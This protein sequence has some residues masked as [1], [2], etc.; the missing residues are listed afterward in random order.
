MT[1]DVKKKR[2][3]EGKKIPTLPFIKKKLLWISIIT[4]MS[5]KVPKAC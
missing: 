2:S 3:G 4:G 1:Y 5:L